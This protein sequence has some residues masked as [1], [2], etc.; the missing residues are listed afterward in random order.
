VLARNA[1]REDVDALDILLKSNALG[2]VRL[3]RDIIVVSGAPPNGALV[4]R[5]CALV[6]EFACPGLLTA[7]ALVNYA[8]GQG[9]GRTAV[10]RD[11]VFLVDAA[12]AAMLSHA[13]RLGAIEYPGKVF[14]LDVG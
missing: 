7:N 4:W 3:D 8:V 5:P 2:D 10:I 6:H 14:T 1:R 11:V 9:S 12:N 13:R